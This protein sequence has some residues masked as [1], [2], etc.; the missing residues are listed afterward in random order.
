MVGKR[1]E[2]I[3]EMT[4]YIK[5]RTQIVH[6]VKQIFTENMDFMGLIRYPMRQFV[7]EKDI[8]DWQ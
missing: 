5:V 4:A 3:E 2:N 7:V 1:V 8:S 6:S